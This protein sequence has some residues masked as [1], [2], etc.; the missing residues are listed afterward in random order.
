MNETSRATSTLDLLEAHHNDEEFDAMIARNKFLS[1]CKA[2][3]FDRMKRLGLISNDRTTKRGIRFTED[4]KKEF[5]SRAYQLRQQGLTYKS[6]QAELGGIT[7]K[8]I[9][10]WIKKYDV[11]SPK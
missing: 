2:K 9:R 4:Q 10:D 5:A 6:I 11:S 3:G 8:S 7:E 1:E